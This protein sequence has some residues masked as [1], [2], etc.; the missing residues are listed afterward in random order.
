MSEPTTPPKNV[1]TMVLFSLT[2]DPTPA[3]KTPRDEEIAGVARDLQ[4][5][6]VNA[7]LAALSTQFNGG[8][9]A[10]DRIT[11]IMGRMGAAGEQIG[12]ALAASRDA[13]RWPPARVGAS[14]SVAEIMAVRAHAEMVAYWALGAAHGLGNVLL[15]ML[16]L[17]AGARPLIEASYP[18]A[19]TFSPFSDDRNAWEPLGPKLVGNARKAAAAVGSTPVDEITDALDALNQDPRWDAL[20]ALRGVNFHQWR[21]Q[22][23]DRGT[24]KHSM[25]TQDALGREMIAVGTGPTN[26]APDH[27]Q[28]LATVDAGLDALVDAAALIDG[29]I[30]AGLNDVVGIEIFKV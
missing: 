29:N 30:F 2:P 13:R 10:I 4:L 24:P 20:M 14:A 26:I 8:R 6:A 16:W 17:H 11:E 18:K 22:S 19:Q 23:V 28:A 21:P 9:W 3:M 27:E 1:A 25:V 7:P 15:R 12:L 5:T